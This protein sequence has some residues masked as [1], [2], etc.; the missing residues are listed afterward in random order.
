MQY[1]YKLYKAHHPCIV[2]SSVAERI[3]QRHKGVNCGQRERE[4]RVE[5]ETKIKWEKQRDSQNQ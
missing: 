2:R 5:T 1:T 4:D 3:S